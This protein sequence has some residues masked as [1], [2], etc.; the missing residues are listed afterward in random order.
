MPSW[1]ENKLLLA[2]LGGLLVA[3]LVVSSFVLVPN[4]MEVRRIRSEREEALKEKIDELF[5][6]G[7][8]IPELKRSY[9]QSNAELQERLELL[10]DELSRPFPDPLIP[11]DELDHRQAYVRDTLEILEGEILKSAGDRNV[12]WAAGKGEAPL[13]LTISPE[14]TESLE[15]DLSLLRR[16]RTAADF[17]RLLLRH[18]EEPHAGGVKNLLQVRELK[19]QAGVLTGPPPQFIREYRVTADLTVSLPGLMRIL[20]ACTASEQFFLVKKLTL[21]AEPGNRQAQ[22]VVRRRRREEGGREITR[23]AEHYYEVRM[24]V[25]RMEVVDTEAEA[26]ETEKPKK[27]GPPT[28]VPHG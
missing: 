20:H 17:A 2:T 10:A 23:W 22:L 24:T 25:A 26:Q 12:M 5:G 11:P 14:Y 13:G 28:A 19:P 21:S 6:S 3:Y 1:Q 7:R 15:Q 27:K 4:A 18:S 16:M 9:E 8:S